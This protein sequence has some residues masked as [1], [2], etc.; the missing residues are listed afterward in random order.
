MESKWYSRVIIF[1]VVISIFTGWY[2]LRDVTVGKSE[3]QKDEREIIKS[4]K[5]IAAIYREPSAKKIVGN[6]IV[7]EGEK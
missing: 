1:I 7:A 5:E 2:L 3:L 4:E 6:I